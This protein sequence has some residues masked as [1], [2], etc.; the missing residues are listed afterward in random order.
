MYVVCTYSHKGVTVDLAHVDLFEI[1]TYS[2]FETPFMVCPARYRA[3]QGSPFF[4]TEKFLD[5]FPKK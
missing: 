2:I 5:I 3:W 1:C 4:K